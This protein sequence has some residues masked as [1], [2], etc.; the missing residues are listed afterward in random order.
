MEDKSSE[1]KVRQQVA[2]DNTQE[3]PQ[4]TKLIWRNF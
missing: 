4:I 1:P 3:S 2:R